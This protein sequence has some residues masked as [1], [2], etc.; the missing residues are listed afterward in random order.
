MSDPLHRLDDATLAGAL[1][2][3]IE[4]ENYAWAMALLE[5]SELAQENQALFNIYVKPTLDLVL[6]REVPEYGISEGDPEGKGASH[7]GSGEIGADSE[8]GTQ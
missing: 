7:T 3:A 2:V 8:E 5:N 6:D 1:A 4:E